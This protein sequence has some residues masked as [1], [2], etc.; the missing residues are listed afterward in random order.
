MIAKC[1]L[2][3]LRLTPSLITHHSSPGASSR[4]TRRSDKRLELLFQKLGGGDGGEVAVLRTDDLHSDRQTLFGESRRRDAR[5]QPG[6]SRVARPE[7]LSRGGLRFAVDHDHA[8]PAFA[9][10]VVRE[11]RGRGGWAEQQVPIAEEL[12][13][14]EAHQ[15]AL[16]VPAV[17][18]AL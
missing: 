12:R 17:P 16:L 7:H 18:S 5:R 13:P 9:F 4:K 14:L 1:V 3:T 2:R 11:C 8:F 15:L 6:Q 10:L